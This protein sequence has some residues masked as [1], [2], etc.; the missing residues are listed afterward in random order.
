MVECANDAL[1]NKN[2]PRFWREVCDVMFILELGLDF[3]QG[4]VDG[5]DGDATLFDDV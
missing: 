1:V 2:L 3:V 5:F 4:G